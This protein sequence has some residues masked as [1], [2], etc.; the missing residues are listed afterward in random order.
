MNLKNVES[1]TKNSNYLTEAVSAVSRNE[2]YYCFS[3]NCDVLT[4]LSMK[5]EFIQYVLL[6][7]PD[8]WHF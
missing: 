4:L 3:T 2:E 7:T 5:V 8:T 1:L 6:D